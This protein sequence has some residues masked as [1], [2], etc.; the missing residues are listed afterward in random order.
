ME[1]ESKTTQQSNLAEKLR[2]RDIETVPVRHVPYSTGLIL[3]ADSINYKLVYSGD[4][5]PSREL[6]RRGKDCHLL[7]HEAT[8][9]DSKTAMAE[10]LM[11]STMSQAIEVGQ[12]MNAKNVVLTHFS[13]ILSNDF[14]QLYKKTSDNVFIAHDFM[15]INQSVID[16]LKLLKSNLNDYKRN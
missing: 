5:S 4:C 13:S 16:K 8:F 2:L 7:I 11:H 9:D 6:V 10:N 12:S 15:R 14:S 3:T 1:A